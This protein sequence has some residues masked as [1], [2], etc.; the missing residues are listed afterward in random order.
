MKYDVKDLENMDKNELIAKFLS[1]HESFKLE[2]QAEKIKSEKKIQQ[3]ETHIAWLRKQLF[4]KKSEKIIATNNGSKQLPLFEDEYIPEDT[5]PEKTVTVKE[6]EKKCRKKATEFS[7]RLQYDDSVEV[8]EEVIEPEEIKGLSE[9]KY[10]VIGGV[11]EK[12]CA[13]LLS[14]FFS[15]LRKRPKGCKK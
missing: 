7:G 9:D 4:G 11:L 6:Y 14:D 15:E 10:E 13:A 2:L 1:L 8:I 12:E 5:P 3:L